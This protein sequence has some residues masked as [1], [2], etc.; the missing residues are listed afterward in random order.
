MFS[1]L[2]ADEKNAL[3]DEL[4]E[5]HFLKGETIIQVGKPN[6]VFYILEAG[7]VRYFAGRVSFYSILVSHDV[8]FSRS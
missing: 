2:L 8:V 6:D 3:V 4:T 5:K 1:C 7:K